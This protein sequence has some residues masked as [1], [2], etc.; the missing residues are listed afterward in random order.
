VKPVR[1][2]VAVPVRLYGDALA[3][4]LARE[5]AIEIAGTCVSRDEVTRGIRA[6]EPDVLL[7]DPELPGAG[8]LTG[9]RSTGGTDVRLILLARDAG[10][11]DLV[12]ALRGAAEEAAGSSRADRRGDGPQPRLTAREREIIELI[13]EGLSNKEIARALSIEVPTVKNHV[14]HVLEKLGASR[15]GQAAARLRH[16][17]VLR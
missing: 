1:I 6:L 14:H 13:D 3:A 10:M 11:A 2:L 16:S 17:G 15:R 5:A 9:T 7:L 12:R 8:D 4:A